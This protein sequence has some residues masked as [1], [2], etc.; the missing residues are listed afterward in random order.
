[1]SGVLQGPV[2]YLTGQTAC[3]VGKLTGLP[4]TCRPR[5]RGHEDPVDARAAEDAIRRGVWRNDDVV[6]DLSR[7]S[8]ADRWQVAWAMIGAHSYIHLNAT[9]GVSFADL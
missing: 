5:V 4:V 2:R 6:M 9:G 7:M 1:M 8:W 3:D